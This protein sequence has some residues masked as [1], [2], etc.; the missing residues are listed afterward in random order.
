MLATKAAQWQAGYGV[1]SFGTRALE[2]IKEYVRNL[3]LAVEIKRGGR[4]E[5]LLIEG[6]PKTT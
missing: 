3:L 1:V 2:W 4:R 6:T 5:H